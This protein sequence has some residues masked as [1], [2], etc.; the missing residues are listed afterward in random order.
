[1]KR[2]S[3]FH[4]FCLG[5]ALIG[6]GL[7]P[8]HSKASCANIN[9][10]TQS[11][12]P[13]HQMPVLDQDGIGACYAYNA[14]QRMDYHIFKNNSE[15]PRQQLR[16]DPIWLA[17][18]YSQGRGRNDLTGGFTSDTINR[19]RR[20]GVCLQEVV[21]C[22][23]DACKGNNDL[24]DAELVDF[25][26]HVF[27]LWESHGELSDQVVREAATQCYARFQGHNFAEILRPVDNAFVIG[28]RRHHSNRPLPVRI[29]QDALRNCS[30]N[31][32]VK[33]DVPASKTSC[34]RCN[35]NQM[36]EKIVELLRGG[37]PVGISYCA[38]MLRDSKYRGIA[39]SRNSRGRVWSRSSRVISE[40]DPEVGKK[41]KAGCGRHASMIT[42]SRNHNGQCQ[43][44][45][46]N[47]WGD[48]KYRGRDVQ[49][50]CVCQ[51]GEGEYVACTGRD[52]RRNAVGCW[53]PADEIISNTY[54]LDHF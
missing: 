39:D 29:L 46:R 19:A 33:P 7:S 26:H 34:D 36:Q 42:G 20:E 27:R 48:T 13:L 44:L 43:L 53:F 11:G 12:S 47:T 31:N 22:G 50:E 51:T 38:T 24:T 23:L 9:L 45:L 21:S 35:D 18:K 1:M 14:A 52:G 8:Q 32:L 5:L 17:L 30:G 10:Q 40:S 49:P 41:G 6:L 2:P 15:T 3:F 25:I 54:Q 4:Q 28:G 16:T 37:Q